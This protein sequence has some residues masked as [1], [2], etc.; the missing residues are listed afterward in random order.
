MTASL[1]AKAGYG[2]LVSVI[3]P[4]GQ[5]SPSS[6]VGQDQRGKAP[7]LKGATGWHGY[8]FTRRSIS[9]DVIE[10]TGANTGLMGDHFPGV[11]VDVDEPALSAAIVRFLTREL[12]DAPVRTSRGSRRLLVYRTIEPYTRAALKIEYRGGHHMVEILGGGRQYVVH[13]AHPS[14]TTYGWEGAPLW[15]WRPRDVPPLGRERANEV[16]GLLKQRL[17]A[18]GAVCALVGDGRE[19]TERAPDQDSL[20]APSLEEL[21]SV[22]SRIPNPDSYGWDD[23]VRVGYAVKAAGGEDAYPLWLA[24]SATHPAHDPD[25]DCRNWDSFQGPFRAGWG[26]LLELAE[27]TGPDPNL[28][29]AYEFTADP[30]AVR[31]K[32]AGQNLSEAVVRS[33]GRPIMLTDEWVVGEILGRLRGKIRY[34]PASK[35]WYTWCGDVW[36]RDEVLTAEIIARDELLALSLLLEDAGKMIP[37]KGEARVYE[38]TARRIQS[39][40]GINSILR[41]CQAHLAVGGDAFDPDP[42]V[43]NTPGGV[44]D[45]HTG[46]MSPTAPEAMCAR[47]TGVAPVPGPRPMWD[48]FI[49]FA[50]HDDPDMIRYLQR[51]LGY[52]L[53]GD[54]SE[55]ALWYVWGSETDT[56]KSTFIRTIAGVMGSYH[57]SV[58]AEVFLDASQG[59]IPAELAR[60]PGARLVTAT[61]PATGASWNEKRVKAITGGDP[62]EVRFL[63]G[64]PFVYRPQYKIVIV[65]NSEPEIHHVDSAMLRRIHI[66][67]MNRQVPRG[68]QIPDLAERMIAEE[69]PAILAWI[70]DGLRGWRAEGLSTPARVVERTEAYASSEDLMG[71]WIEDECA[72]ERGAEV[73]RHELFSA[74]AGWCRSHGERPGGTRQFKRLLDARKIKFGIEDARVGESR[75]RGYQGI[76]LRSAAPGDDFTTEGAT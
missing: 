64:Q 11:D 28:S 36:C 63:Y 33:G 45:L 23:Y 71:Q 1:I 8:S 15:D 43:L 7:G 37:A 72:V 65:G 6:K 58:D 49:G 52:A 42:W 61:E 31:P 46:E 35:L 20:R 54:V 51:V 30:G 5:L 9:P 32:P 59:R 76:R 26:W 53:T 13:G 70:L 44:V 69:G 18:R 19:P 2:P 60:L 57:D 22:L 39:H 25:M 3:P 66:V 55:K 16:L 73:S 41:L 17:E 38:A 27:D 4:D 62:I 56:G 24:W 50:C 12:G 21:G 47:V 68:A 74:W 10:E 34:V 14:G 75:A 48:A 67:P 29:A 40:Q